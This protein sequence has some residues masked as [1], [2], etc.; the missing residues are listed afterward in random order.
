MYDLDQ[1]GGRSLSPLYR[2]TR[3]PYATLYERLAASTS[4]PANE[5]SCWCW[6]RSKR[7]RAG[8]GRLNVYVP[9]LLKSRTMYA[10]VAMWLHLALPSGYTLDDLYLAW[11]ELRCS[12][13]Q[14]DHLCHNPS[15]LFPDHLDPEPVTPKE[16]IARRRKDV[17]RD[18]R[19]APELEEA[20]A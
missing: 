2:R 13:L 3:S 11:V 6:D 19:L 7:D 16:N 4:E 12:G 8:Y 15:C 9:G 1:Y 5:Q 10:H 14:V 20:F 17:W 18:Y